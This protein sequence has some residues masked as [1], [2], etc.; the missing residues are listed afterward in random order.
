[1]GSL[2]P[3]SLIMRDSAAEHRVSVNEDSGV[4]VDDVA[5]KTQLLGDG[6]V[7][8][9]ERT[10]HVAWVAA[11]GDVRW[12]YFDGEVYELEVVRPGRRMH[13]GAGPGSLSAPMPATVVRIEVAPGDRVRHGDTLIILEAMKMELPVRASADGVVAA[14]HCRPGELVQPGVSLLSMMNDE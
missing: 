6:A 14:I 13:K 2:M 3:R 11:A 7:R 8:I 10:G 12:V 5:V 9:H 1:M 4:R